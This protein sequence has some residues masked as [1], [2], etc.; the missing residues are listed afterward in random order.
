M[1]NVEMLARF[2]CA[3]LA[4]RPVPD[5][6]T[7]VNALLHP[8]SQQRCA[9]A[10]T[11]DANCTAFVYGYESYES[12]GKDAAVPKLCSDVSPSCLFSNEDPQ[13]HV[14]RCYLRSVSHLNCGDSS[15]GTYTGGGHM[16]CSMKPGGGLLDW[17][18]F[19]VYIRNQ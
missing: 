1:S 13:C 12:G 15:C 6:S 4:C 19:S 5:N 7:P 11:A 8:W 17:G 2:H 16:A 18:E 3:V 10:C 9:Q 14:P